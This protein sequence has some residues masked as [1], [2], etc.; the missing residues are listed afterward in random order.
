MYW[1]LN[2]ATDAQFRS[3]FRVSRRLFND[4][5]DYLSGV[6]EVNPFSFRG[7]EVHPPEA[8]AM[9]LQFMGTQAGHTITADAFL[10]GNTTVK[11]HVLRASEGI[12]ATFGLNGPH[13]VISLPT[14]AELNRMANR[15]LERRGM[16]MCVGS[17]DG[18]HFFVKY[19]LSFS[20]SYIIVCVWFSISSVHALKQPLSKRGFLCP[21]FLAPFVFMFSMFGATSLFSVFPPR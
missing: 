7:D 6:L 12:I 1:Y 16:P 18:K 3:R 11:K 21:S 13:S 14:A 4:L 8:I 20:C 19:V 2:N 10:R 15:N 17:L 9:T 5:K